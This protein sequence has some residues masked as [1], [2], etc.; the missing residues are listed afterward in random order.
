MKLFMI[1][2]ELTNSNGFLMSGVTGGRK[3]V[4]NTFLKKYLKERSTVITSKG[5]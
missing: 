3:M 4:Q 1:R 2:M 5:L